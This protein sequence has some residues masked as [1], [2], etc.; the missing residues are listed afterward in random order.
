M[1]DKAGKI[2]NQTKKEQQELM[3]RIRKQ[4]IEKILMQK[5]LTRP[6][7]ETQAQ[8]NETMEL[9]EREDKEAAAKIGNLNL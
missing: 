2:A 8:P 7:N 5:R 9:E 1:E 3:Q 4:R 6:T